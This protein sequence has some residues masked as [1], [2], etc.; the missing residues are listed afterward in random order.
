[1]FT[2]GLNKGVNI[3][4]RGQISPLGAKFTPRGEVIPRGPGV[5]LRMALWALAPVQQTKKNNFCTTNH[6]PNFLG[7]QN[8]P[9]RNGSWTRLLEIGGWAMSTLSGSQLGVTS[10]E[11]EINRVSVGVEG[12]SFIK[13]TFLNQ[14]Q[15]NFAQLPLLTRDMSYAS[16]WPKMFTPRG[17]LFTEGPPLWL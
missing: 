14:S 15:P 16:F 8:S 10:F 1:V 7:Y 3:P 4:P 5:K 11:D 17:T 2:P 12:F 13:S 9:T 6:I